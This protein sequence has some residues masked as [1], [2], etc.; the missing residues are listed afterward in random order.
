M[1]DLTPFAL[2]TF[3]RSPLSRGDNEF[4]PW[5]AGEVA[6]PEAES[7]GARGG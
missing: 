4:L 6:R 3:E 2:T 7:E 5:V 1:S